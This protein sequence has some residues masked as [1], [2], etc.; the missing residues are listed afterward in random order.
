ML[1]RQIDRWIPVLHGPGC[2]RQNEASSRLR[3]TL[4]SHLTAV[5]WITMGFDEDLDDAGK[6]ALRD[7]IALV[8]E[9]SGLG[10]RVLHSYAEIAAVLL[11]A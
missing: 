3:G 4:K 10:D 8:R 6:A 7:M 1:I 11:A 2:P 5:D 9:R